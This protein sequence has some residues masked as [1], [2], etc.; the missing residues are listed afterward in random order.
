MDDAE[1]QIRDGIAPHGHPGRKPAKND[2]AVSR[3]GLLD[4]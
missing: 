1:Y 4:Y 3:L 2:G